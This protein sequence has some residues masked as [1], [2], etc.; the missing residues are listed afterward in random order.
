[1]RHLMKE[2]PRIYTWEVNQ[3]DLFSQY[4]H[5]YLHTSMSMIT[6][7]LLASAS[8]SSTDSRS[9]APSRGGFIGPVETSGAGPRYRTNPHRG[10]CA[11]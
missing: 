6:T 7:R 1:M 5:S 8:A 10:R 11:P 9:A 2:V 3:D 4:I